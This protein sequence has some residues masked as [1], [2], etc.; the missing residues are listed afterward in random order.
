MTYPFIFFDWDDTLLFSTYTH[1]LI[2]QIFENIRL[3]KEFNNVVTYKNNNNNLSY[4]QRIIILSM[5]Q[6]DNLNIKLLTNIIQYGK[7]FI[8][9]NA[10]LS[11]FMDSARF[12]LPLTNQ[13]IIDN[14]IETY[15]A[16]DMYYLKY[17]V[18]NDENHTLWKYYTF[19]DILNK[20]QLI[21]NKHIVSIGDGKFEYNA[22]KRIGI[23]F[24]K[25]YTVNLVKY[26][27][28]PS[29][30]D[31]QMQI[32]GTTKIVDKIINNKNK[33]FDFEKNML[34]FPKNPN[35]N[36]KWIQIAY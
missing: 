3:N 30:T 29:I 6:L 27:V 5:I 4:D 14:K 23:K 25:Y 17:P 12:Y 31:M 2:G 1:S 15:S 8:V 10:S 34:V 28:Y 11:W 20:Y 21:H 19:L 36:N 9:T 35:K 32:I 13:F 16:H 18:L 26:K 22:M 24:G 33:I 7:I